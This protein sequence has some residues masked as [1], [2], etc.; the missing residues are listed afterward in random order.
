MDNAASYGLQY[1]Y[2]SLEQDYR[3]NKR[4]GGV[5]LYIHESLQYQRKEDLRIGKDSESI[6]S[7]FI[8]IDELTIGTK[9]NVVIGCI[10]RPPWVNL[11]DFN[12][13]LNGTLQSCDTNNKYVYILGDFNV[14]LSHNIKT[15]NATEDLKNLFSMHHFAPLIN[16]PTREMKN[17]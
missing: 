8:E 16:K 9:Y 13:L 15:N 1:D 14:D 4:G 10:Y 12:D 5:C 6:N 2:Y 17:S 7:L 3:Q 11:S